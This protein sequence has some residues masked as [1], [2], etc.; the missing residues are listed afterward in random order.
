M[1]KRHGHNFD[2]R[3]YMEEDGWGPS[4]YFE[5][6]IVVTRTEKGKKISTILDSFSFNEA[7]AS[8]LD[9]TADNYWDINVN[10]LLS[11]FAITNE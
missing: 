1:V 6:S 4:T 9:I 5:L 3:L 8:Y 2:L 10:E 11:S 7:D